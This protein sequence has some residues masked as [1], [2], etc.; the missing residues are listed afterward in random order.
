MYFTSKKGVVHFSV[1]WG[2]FVFLIFIVIYDFTLDISNVISL[3]VVLIFNICIIWIWFRT[4][5]EIKNTT[6]VI[7]MGPYKKEI[8]I[9]EIKTIKR[10]K[11]ILSAPTLSTDRLIIQY[12]PYNWGIMI[13]PKNESSFVRQLIDKNP[14][15]KVTGEHLDGN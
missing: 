12:G 9:S 5:Y 6:V 3:V 2:F 11:N 1:L 15:I 7:K 10:C 8:S 14:H 4:G 13:S